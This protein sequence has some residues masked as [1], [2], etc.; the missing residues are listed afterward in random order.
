MWNQNF[1]IIFPYYEIKYIKCSIILPKEG[2]TQYFFTF[3]SPFKHP[4]DKM[5]T[6]LLG[7]GTLLNDCILFANHLPSFHPSFLTYVNYGVWWSLPTATTTKLSSRDL[8]RA[9]YSCFSRKKKGGEE[10]A[11]IFRNYNSS[12]LDFWLTA[13]CLYPEMH[14]PLLLNVWLLLRAKIWHLQCFRYKLLQVIYV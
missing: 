6:A 3:R 13:K 10:E 12:W 9:C 8:N 11:A 4:Q 14:Y 5:V 1:L 7:T 2:L